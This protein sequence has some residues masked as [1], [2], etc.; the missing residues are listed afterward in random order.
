[1]KKNP[2]L[3]IQKSINY[4][5]LGFWGKDFTYE[6]IMSNYIIYWVFINGSK[7][8]S[9]SRSQSYFILISWYYKW[10]YIFENQLYICINNQVVNLDIKANWQ[11]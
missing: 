7:W 1:M 5:G 6:F 10:K 8:N 2:I 11:I 4:F 3:I 9:M